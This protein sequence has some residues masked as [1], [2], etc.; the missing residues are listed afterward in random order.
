MDWSFL[1]FLAEP[2]FVVPW[3]LVGVLGAAW[4]LYDTSHLNTQPKPAMKWAWPII[5]LFLSAIGLTV[6]FWSARPPGIGDKQ[7][8]EAREAYDAYVE[9]MPRKVMGSVIHCV[10]GDG[11]GIIS[12]MVLA[13]V[14]NMS[15]WQEFWFEYA[16]GFC[17]G[18]FIFQYKAMRKM[19]DGVLQTL[20]MGGRAEFFS[21]LTVM[22]G[23]GAVMAFVTPLVVGE[24]PK[25]DTFA[26][27][28]FSM[29]GLL[30]GFVVTYPMNWALV[31][32]GW[33]HGLGHSS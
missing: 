24:Q 5:V 19:A 1:S 28:G 14:L 6:Y 26:F 7:G 32:I 2:W 29:F 11:L 27:W 25:P 8:Q 16:V 23:M 21:M 9:K 30:V 10:G 12:A 15:F 3:Y 13:R 33:K 4:V 22:A 17:F 20:W 31:R 18:W